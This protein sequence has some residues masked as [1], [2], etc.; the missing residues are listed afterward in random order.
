VAQTQAVRTVAVAALLAAR[1][2]LPDAEA[3]TLLREV[4]DGIDFFAAGGAAGSQSSRTT[5]RTG[6]GIPWHPAAERFFAR[7][8][9]ASATP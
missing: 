9:Q 2:D 8:S 3:E 1:A 7:A 6:V 4:F 5:A